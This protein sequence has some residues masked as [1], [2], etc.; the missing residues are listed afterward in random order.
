V[1]KRFALLLGGP[2]AGA[3][4]LYR[5]LGLHPQVLACRV[6]EPR[7]FSDERKF[8]LGLDWYRS[9]WDFR[10]PDDR[11]AVEASSDYARHPLVPCPAGR[12]A[13]TPAGFRFVYLLRDPV[14]RVAAWHADRVASGFA[15][16]AVDL[17]DLQAEIVSCRY[18]RQLSAWREHFPREDFLLVPSEEWS[19]HPAPVFER[20]CRFL[21]L[22]DDF[23]LPEAPHTA[24]GHRR[25]HARA[26]A[27]WRSR[28]ADR[29]PPAQQPASASLPAALADAL[30][31]ELA[32]ERQRLAEVWGFDPPSWSGEGGA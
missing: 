19:L 4:R 10:E 29:R 8:A 6:M 26:L 5:Q 3:T 32:P 24:P 21:E 16:P 14:E 11:V 31:R 23:A 13:R 7:F 25:G 28:V 15:A 22:D 1:K 20:V 17:S 9:L 12:V 18:A 27:W 2:H 30:R